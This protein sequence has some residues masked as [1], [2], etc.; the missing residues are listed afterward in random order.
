[1][2]ND[3]A[4]ITESPLNEVV[5]HFYQLSTANDAEVIVNHIMP[6]YEMHMIFNFGTPIRFSF[7][8][9]ELNETTI[10]NT[11]IM[12][13][14]RKKLTYEVRPNSDAIVVNFTLNG[15]Y[16]LFKI[17]VSELTGECLLDPDVLIGDTCFHELWDKLNSIKDTRKR[18]SLLSDYVLAFLNTNDKAA[19]PLI[20]SAPY[21]NNPT[22]QPVKAI[23][24]DNNLTERSIQLRFKKYVGY[25]PKEL[26]RFLRFKDV[27]NHLLTHKDTDLFEV[28]EKYGYYDQSHLGKDFKHFLG[29][30][31][32]QFINS[33]DGQPFC[34]R[35]AQNP[36]KL[37]VETSQK[38]F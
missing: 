7:N 33:L 5:S 3:Q 18:I 31:P 22:V 9:E 27:I 34:T 35:P 28:I 19:L 8:N 24:F 11:A 38:S 10:S 17:P 37:V 21:F 6:N 29:T 4:F 16:R 14:L 20:K 1:M 12:G 32:Q 13:P 23:A 2:I 25:S 30:T 15:F 36:I 26:I